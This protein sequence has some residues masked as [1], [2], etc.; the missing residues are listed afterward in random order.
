[1]LIAAG[2]VL[3]AALC[4]VILVS[5]YLHMLYVEA[6]RFHARGKLRSVKFFEKHLEAKLGFDEDEA[7]RRYALAWQLAAVTLALD[8][9]LL[10][11]PGQSIPANT[12]RVPPTLQCY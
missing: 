2:I 10:T 6:S 5:S 8:L 4:G 1:M 11:L 9:L 12:G 7:I 3:A